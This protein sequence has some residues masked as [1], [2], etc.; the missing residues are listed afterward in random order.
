HANFNHP[1]GAVAYYARLLTGIGW[2]CS[3]HAKDIWTA[4]ESDLRRKLASAE[5]VVTCTRAG[6]E[7]LRALAARPDKVHLSYHGLDLGRFGPIEGERPPRDGS[8]ASGPV[9]VLSIGR[10]VEKKGYDVLLR[11]LALLPSSINWRFIHI[12]G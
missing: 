8:D 9:I 7:R 4:D 6:Y 11:A 1:P 3:A 2:S 5:W 12:G 10:A